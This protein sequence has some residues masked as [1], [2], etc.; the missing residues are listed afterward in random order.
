MHKLGEKFVSSAQ[1]GDL[2]SMQYLWTNHC[3]ELLDYTR[4]RSGDRSVH[5]AARHCHVEVLEFLKA[6]GADLEAANLDGK[7]PLHEAVASGNL[8]CVE[9]LLSSGVLVDPLKRADW[10]ESGK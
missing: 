8:S 9:F 3:K 6:E 4:P 1:K 5:L 7:R 2:K 10:Y